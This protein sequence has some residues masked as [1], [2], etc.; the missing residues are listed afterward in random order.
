M[1]QK[2]ALESL[3]RREA[4]LLA[5]GATMVAAGGVVS[6]RTAITDGDIE[7]AAYRFSKSTGF[8]F[9][10]VEKGDRPV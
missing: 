2:K 10:K 7:L 4:L 1:S 6:D 5:A 8:A 9:L 3:S